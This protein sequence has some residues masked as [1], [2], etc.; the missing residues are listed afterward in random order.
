M[1][2]VSGKSSIRTGDVHLCPFDDGIKG[3]YT[4]AAEAEETTPRLLA[5]RYLLHYFQSDR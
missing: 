2:T 3:G 5:E 1:K 4:A